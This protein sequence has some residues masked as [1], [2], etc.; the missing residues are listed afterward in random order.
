VGQFE[1]GRKDSLELS[2]AAGPLA[3]G[4]ASKL[5]GYTGTFKLTC[6]RQTC[7]RAAAP[8]FRIDKHASSIEENRWKSMPIAIP[9]AAVA[10]ATSTAAISAATPAATAAKSTSTAAASSAESTA[11]TTT[12]TLFLGSGF[13]DGQGATVVLLAVQGR[14]G[15]LGLLVAGH[16]HKT[17][18][19]ASA[20]VTIVD[21]LSRHHRAVLGK[22]FLESRAVHVVTEIPHVQLL[23][24]CRSPSMGSP[25]ARDQFFRGRFEEAAIQPGETQAP[26]P[27][28]SMY[29]TPK[30]GG[31]EA[32]AE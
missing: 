5:A 22:Q 26:P 30:T 7:W 18:T 8:I 4:P 21:D 6:D 23:T 11:T 2:C 14:D 24:H 31:E 27:W 17:K 9:A 15:G 13:I 12:G 29:I 10:A 19:F 3:G 16:F 20:R 1:W 28:E 25:Q 32:S